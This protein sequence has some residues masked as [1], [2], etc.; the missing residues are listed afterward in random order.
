[1]PKDMSIQ[2]MRFYTINDDFINK[3][4]SLE[5]K[6]QNNYNGTRPYIGILL[7][8]NGLNYYA[9]LSSYKPKQDRINNITVFKLYEKGNPA[10]KLGV[11]HINNMFPVPIDQLTEVTIDISEKYGRL[12]QNQYEYILHYQDEIQ[13]QAQQLYDVANKNKNSFLA[14]ISCD[15]KLLEK[16][17]NQ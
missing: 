5:P 4:K 9:P 16:H 14:K 10:N 8:V 3:M 11:I 2:L 7:T 17:F 13:K 12:L 15:F 1:M 6:I